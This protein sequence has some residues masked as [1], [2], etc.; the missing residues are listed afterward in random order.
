MRIVIITSSLQGTAATC[1]PP[2]AEHPD[3]EIAL[4]IYSRGEIVNR[5]RARRRKLKK[6]WKIGLLGALNGLR[7]RPWFTAGVARKLGP[8]SVTELAARYGF[9]LEE[10]PRVNCARTIELMREANADLGVSLGNGYLGSKVFSAPK[11]GMINSHGEILPQFQGAQSVIWQLYEG[12]AETGYTIHQ[13]DR[14]IDTGP[15]LYQEKIPLE[16]QPTLRETVSHNCARIREAASKGLPYVVSHYPELAAQSRPQ[17]GGRT[18]TTP[19][20][21][22]FLR[23][24]WQ[25]R[26]LYRQSLAATANRNLSHS[27]NP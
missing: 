6:L 12:Q 25:H 8:T 14:H 13:I 23:I 5:A 9:R 4:V 10:T 24:W 11:Y 1:I 21:W 22:Q 15:I 17:S 16:L 20:F 2:L 19:S 18:Y 3:I 7:I 27:D 26:K